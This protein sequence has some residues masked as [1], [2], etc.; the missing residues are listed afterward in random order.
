MPG[1]KF[2]YFRFNVTASS[3]SKNYFHL[4]EMIFYDA[5]VDIYDPETV[6]LD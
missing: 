6:S 5:E 3:Q 2:K 1:K 4:G